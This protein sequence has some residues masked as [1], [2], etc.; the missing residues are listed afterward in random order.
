NCGDDQNLERKK[1]KR[2]NSEGEVTSCFSHCE[3]WRN[4][5]LRRI[6][7]DLFAKCQDRMLLCIEG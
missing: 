7:E 6:Y 5:L 2:N 1:R 3:K 4:G